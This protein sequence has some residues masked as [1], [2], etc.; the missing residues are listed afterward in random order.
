MIHDT[1]MQHPPKDVKSASTAA[2]LASKGT[3]L[4][5][6][7]HFF[8]FL[9]TLPLGEP[10]QRECSNRVSP[11]GAWHLQKKPGEV[12]SAAVY[13]QRN[14]KT[15][16]V[17]RDNGD[18]NERTAVRHPRPGIQVN[19]RMDAPTLAHKQPETIRQRRY[20]VRCDPFCSFYER[21]LSLFFCF[22]RSD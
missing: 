19:N 2:F 5:Y 7:P 15:T 10:P 3:Y 22:T 14:R 12:A 6:L 1:S 4:R 11:K 20:N 17:S 8:S 16:V 21:V 18:A 9:E 13:L